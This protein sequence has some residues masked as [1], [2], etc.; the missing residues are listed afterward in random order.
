MNEWLMK[1]I[2]PEIF[3]LRE[4]LYSYINN[5]ICNENSIDYLECGVVQGD[6]ILKWAAINS[7]AKSR[8]RRITIIF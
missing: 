1:N 7:S 2:T 8:I 5:T 3:D 6:N 4:D